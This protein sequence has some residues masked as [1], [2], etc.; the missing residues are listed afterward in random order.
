MSS[1]HRG[2]PYPG[3]DT[4]IAANLIVPSTV[5]LFVACVLYVAR[6]Y[7]R[8]RPVNTLG[9]DDYSVTAAII[10]AI[11]G[12]TLSGVSCYYG[13]GRHS[14]YVSYEHAKKANFF[15]FVAQPMVVWA[16]CLAKCSVAFMLIRLKRTKGWQAFLYVLIFIQVLSAVAA[17]VAQLK[18][19]NPIS[20]YWDPEVAS[21]PTT[22]SWSPHAIQ[23]SA[24]VNA[25][26]SVASDTIFSL[27]PISFLRKMNR[28]LRERIVLGLL[29]GLGMFATLASVF[30]I[31]LIYNYRNIKDP[32]YDVIDL[33]VWWQ[34][35]ENISIIASCIPTLKSPFEKVLRRV[36][37]LTTLDA[38]TANS[39]ARFSSHRGYLKYNGDSAAS[40]R[41][42]SVGNFQMNHLRTEIYGGRTSDLSDGAQ[43]QDAIIRKDQSVLTT[44][45]HPMPPG[46]GINKTL[47]IH[48][49]T[50]DLESARTKL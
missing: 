3:P 21:R 42:N 19:F 15:S 4:S 41:E 48:T 32:L 33:S 37:L 34:M 5:T 16:I 8:T 50:I 26:V 29:M 7:T 28:P 12:V 9:W 17:N 13:T 11:I 49:E 35:E 30:K 2:F 43:S 45:E 6:I 1:D 39:G 24:Y 44:H 25:A 38:G 36:G 47:D 31:T 23:A 10:L 46:G 27:L 40:G 20:A 18:Q 14:Y 22:T